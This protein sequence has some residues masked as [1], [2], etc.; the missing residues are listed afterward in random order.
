[1]SFATKIPD[2][3]SGLN[4]VFGARRKSIYASEVKLRADIL[5]KAQA[6]VNSVILNVIPNQHAANIVTYTTLLRP[7]N[8][9]I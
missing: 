2:H 4:F 9:S 6:V 1:M 5:V 7:T 8:L 3:V